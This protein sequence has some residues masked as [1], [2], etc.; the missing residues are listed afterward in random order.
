[1]T[2]S[3]G[4]P[5]CSACWPAACAPASRRPGDGAAGTH[6]HDLDERV[7]RL[8]ARLDLHGRG[9]KTA[10][11]ERALSALEEQTDGTRPDRA[12]VEAALERLARAGDRFR[13]RGEVGAG[14]RRWQPFVA[15]LAG[16]TLRRT[17]IAQ[18]IVVDTSAIVGILRRETAGTGSSSRH[19]RGR[20]YPDLCGGGRRDGRGIE[21]R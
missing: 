21:S 10:V 20:S 18:V 1:M 7:E 2:G 3:R 8:A 9:R 14:L 16:R 15:G 12:Y 6:R 4:R 13:E 11:I 19:R 5:T 17:R